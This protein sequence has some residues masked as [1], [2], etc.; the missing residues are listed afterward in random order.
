[1]GIEAWLKATPL[2]AGFV[3]VL[4]SIGSWTTH[5]SQIGGFAL[6]YLLF[7]LGIVIELSGNIWL[8]LII[9]SVVTFLFWVIVSF[10]VI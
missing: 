7:W 6:G 1:M 9:A 8:G 4:I 2:M 3:L 5:N 10:L